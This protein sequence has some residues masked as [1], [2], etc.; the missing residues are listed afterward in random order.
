MEA[1]KQACA[2]CERPIGKMERACD[3]KGEIVCLQC[4]D[5]LR[6]PSGAK[7]VISQ[8]PVESNALSDSE[9]I[10]PHCKARISPSMWQQGSSTVLIILLLFLIF[11]AI[12]YIFF[13][14]KWI[15]FCP[16]CK[17]VVNP[18]IGVKQTLMAEYRRQLKLKKS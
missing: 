13:Y 11:P 4:F 9:M 10:C 1:T 8:R 7:V 5:V 3:W 18:S 14:Y 17:A 15:Y 16:E 12:L 2:N 6:Q